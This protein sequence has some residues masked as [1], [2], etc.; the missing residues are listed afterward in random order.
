N[1]YANIVLP[2]VA[3]A[4]PSQLK[5]ALAHEIQH[6]RQC[7]TLW[8]YA[9]EMTKVL[10]AVNPLVKK[11]IQRTMELQELACDEALV[12]HKRFSARAYGECLYGFAEQ[13][14]SK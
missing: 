11:L 9:L 3:L 14:M 7:D 2:Y 12:G 4:Q 1:G 13:Q 6:H 5:M 8:V 10:F